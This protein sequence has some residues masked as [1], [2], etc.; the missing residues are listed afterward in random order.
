MWNQKVECLSEGL[1]VDSPE[2]CTQQ[3][4]NIQVKAYSNSD[5]EGILISEASA[6]I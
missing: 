1:L 2:S 6:H 5:G 4:L 3:Q